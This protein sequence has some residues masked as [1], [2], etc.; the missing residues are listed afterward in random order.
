LIAAAPMRLLGAALF[1]GD[2]NRGTA[3]WDAANAAINLAVVMWEMRRK[4]E[5]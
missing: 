4:K 3:L 2:G 1:L 5:D